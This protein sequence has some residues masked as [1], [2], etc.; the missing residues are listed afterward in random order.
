MFKRYYAG[1]GSNKY[2]S[3]KKHLGL[4]LLSKNFSLEDLKEGYF[5]A[6]NNP[7]FKS[8]LDKPYPCSFVPIFKEDIKKFI[9]VDLE[10]Q[11]I[12]STLKKSKEK[13]P[14]NKKRI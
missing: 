6:E 3:M 13:T 4:M 11:V 12:L 5:L 9:F 8:H 2:L 10:K 7:K 14:E 1:A